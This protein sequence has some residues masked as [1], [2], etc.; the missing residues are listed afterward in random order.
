MTLEAGRKN[1]ADLTL[2]KLYEA[3]LEMVR[4]GNRPQETEPPEGGMR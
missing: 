3:L 2:D 1:L 4:R